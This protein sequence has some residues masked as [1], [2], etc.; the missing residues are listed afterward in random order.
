MSQERGPDAIVADLDRLL[1]AWSERRWRREHPRKTGRE[2]FTAH[3]LACPLS[4]IPQQ[5]P[6]RSVKTPFARDN[7][8]KFRAG[9]A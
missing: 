9:I 3:Q 8:P 6:A 1:D 5:T 7:P 2:P 4:E